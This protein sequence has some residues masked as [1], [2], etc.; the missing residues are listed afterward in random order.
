MK[1]TA[2]VKLNGQQHRRL[3]HYF[4]QVKETELRPGPRV[5]WLLFRSPGSRWIP[6]FNPDKYITHLYYG[7]SYQLA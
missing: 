5:S 6:I 2:M 1:K 4:L 7:A 3:W